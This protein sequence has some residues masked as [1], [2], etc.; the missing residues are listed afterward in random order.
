M[1]ILAIITA[2]KNSKRL[3]NKNKILLNKKKLIEHTFITAKKSKQF[4]Q[5]LL[6]TD[7]K[8]IIKLSKKYNILAPWIRPKSLSGDNTPSYKTV[9]H[10]CDWYEKKFGKVDG[11]FILQPTSPFRKVKTIKDMIK[12]FKKNYKKPVVSLNKCT[13][14]PELMLKL[15]KDKV[16]PYISRKYFTKTTQSFLALFQISGL[17]YLMCPSILRKEKTLVPKNFI[18]YINFSKIETLDIDDKEDYNIA[19]KFAKN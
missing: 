4:D 2:R 17:G 5:I 14:Y 12:I 9:I 10:A 3:K 15:K 8:D 6:T 16:S 1:K 19:K 18:P 7:D 11:I 13:Q